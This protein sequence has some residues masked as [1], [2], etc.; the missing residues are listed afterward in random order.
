MH[1]MAQRGRALRHP[2]FWIAL[3]ILVVND[4]VLKG[5]GVL[6]GW[7]TGKLSDVAGMIVAPVLLVSLLDLRSDRARAAAFGAVAFG[8]AALELSPRAAAG[9]DAMLGALGI[10]SR[11][12]ADPTDLLALAAL[13]IAWWVTKA[14]DRASPGRGLRLAS[15]R[16][17]M[18]A[19]LFACVAT[20]Q[21]PQPLPAEW[22]T[23]AWLHNRTAEAIDVRIRWATGLRDC[24]ALAD[25]AL[26]L[27]ATISPDLFADGITF[28]LGPGDTVPIEP[29]DAA[30]ALEPSAGFAGRPAPGEGVVRRECEL[31]RISV[32]GAPDTLAFWLQGSAEMVLTNIADG[33]ST[34]TADQEIAIDEDG[35]SGGL[36]RVDA[37][38]NYR[39]TELRERG[40]TLPATCRE[41]RGATVAYSDLESATDVEWIVEFRALL[42]DG[43]TQLDLI[44]ELRE[45]TETMFL[46][47]PED[48]VP[49]AVGAR[50]T[51]STDFAGL[52]HVR[53]V[54][55]APELVLA[56]GVS[57]LAVEGLRVSPSGFDL[58]CSER[59]ACGAV[60]APL[61]VTDGGEPLELDAAVSRT[62]G[63]GRAYRALVL[64]AE[65]V[66]LGGADCDAGRDQSGAL[67][68]AVVLFEAGAAE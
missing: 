47:V 39:I 54:E 12:W 50:V 57:S 1:G 7:L 26:D 23:D 59:L 38:R 31:A 21:P 49:F 3:A 33:A 45:R 52:R 51:Q 30:A 15:Q 22:T 58:A 4:H 18:G 66:V 13:P 43:C 61:E 62:T 68:D 60:V 2:A 9:Y 63:A 24:S 19:A 8:F 27:G 10:A 28:R 6:P 42:P 67:I 55:G 5:A 14:G 64:R 17:L 41:A 29:V 11:S 65:Q 56:R 37:G 32:D 16:A 53:A 25:E 46:C 34:E 20:T 36:L 48:F 35:E 40:T 44:D